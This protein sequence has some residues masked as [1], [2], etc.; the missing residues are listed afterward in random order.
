MAGTFEPRGGGGIIDQILS[1]KGTNES[2]DF[3]RKKKAHNEP[4]TLCSL[5]NRALVLLVYLKHITHRL[6]VSSGVKKRWH[7]S[8]H[9]LKCS[10]YPHFRN[11]VPWRQKRG[12]H[13]PQAPLLLLQ[14]LI[15]LYHRRPP[16]MSSALCVF[17][18][19]SDTGHAEGVLIATS[20]GRSVEFPSEGNASF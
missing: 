9:L 18:H 4:N 2:G 17:I 15:C 5:E 20:R 7:G 11:N 8:A 3:E 16:A 19:A 14:T 1:R 10:Q 12:W 6:C 13:V